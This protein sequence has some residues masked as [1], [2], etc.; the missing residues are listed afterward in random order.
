MVR[1]PASSANLGPGYDSLAA[2]LS[3]NL[4]LDV[5]ETGE[6]AVHSDVPG[7]PLDRTNL[8]VKAFERLHTADGLTFRISSEIPV[9]G[10]LRASAAAVVA[11]P[12]APDHIF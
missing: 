7:I 9:S 8:C 2:A 1:V 5:E 4:E 12:V 3:L 10:G 11:G 6:F